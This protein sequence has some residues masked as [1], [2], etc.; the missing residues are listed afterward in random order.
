MNTSCLVS[1][2]HTVYCWWCDDGGDIFLAHFGFLMTIWGRLIT[3]SYSCIVHYQGYPFMTTVSPSAGQWDLSDVSNWILE[4]NNE[5]AVFKR[6]PW[7]PKCNSMDPLCDVVE[8]EIC[9]ID[10]Q[11]QHCVNN[12]KTL[13][14]TLFN[15][16]DAIFKVYVC[17]FV[18]CNPSC[19][20]IIP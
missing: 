1:V 13:L 6:P 17:K 15:L 14:C 18:L 12:L 8:Q 20:I 19:K 4:S 9:I 3:T 11:H 16:C 2:V 10:L 7:S 5:F